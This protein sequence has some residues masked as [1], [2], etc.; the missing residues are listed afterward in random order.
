MV[1]NSIG[2]KFGRELRVLSAGLWTLLSCMKG[3][4][5]WIL[6]CA[7][8]KSTLHPLSRRMLISA[9]IFAIL[10]LLY[11]IS[12][13]LENDKTV[14]ISLELSSCKQPQTELGCSTRGSVQ[15]FF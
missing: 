15:R 4:Q 12:I 9:V 8:W 5:K 11:F 2:E 6:S 3:T 13:G 1:G 10:E 7:C 14:N